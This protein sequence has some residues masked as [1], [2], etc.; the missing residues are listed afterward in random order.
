M[1]SRIL[2]AQ[3]RDGCEAAGRPGWPAGGVRASARTAR[4]V[5]AGA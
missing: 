4:R 5:F 3:A 1:S 2:G